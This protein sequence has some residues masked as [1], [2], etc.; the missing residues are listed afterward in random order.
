MKCRSLGGGTGGPPGGQEGQF[1][2]RSPPAICVQDMMEIPGRDP[3]LQPPASVATPPP[4]LVV[5]R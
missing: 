1:G 5:R 4:E 3:N 2:E